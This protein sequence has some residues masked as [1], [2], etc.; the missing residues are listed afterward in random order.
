M[1]FCLENSYFRKLSHSTMDFVGIRNKPSIRSARLENRLYWWQTS[2]YSFSTIFSLQKL[3]FQP[4]IYT[5]TVHMDLVNSLLGLFSQD[6][7][8]FIWSL[9]LSSFHSEREIVSCSY[10]RETCLKE[11]KENIKHKTPNTY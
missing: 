10:R 2:Y 11:K 9:R 1:V 3:R 4:F 5:E 8:D 7:I 6:H